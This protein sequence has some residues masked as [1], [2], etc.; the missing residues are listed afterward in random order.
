MTQWISTYVEVEISETQEIRIMEEGQ[1]MCKVGVFK[2]QKTCSK[3]PY[4]SEAIFSF[5]TAYLINKLF[6]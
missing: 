5:Y 4:V 6:L 1:N 3:L 2:G